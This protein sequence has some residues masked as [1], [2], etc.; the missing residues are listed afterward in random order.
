M[1][2]KDVTNREDAFHSGLLSLLRMVLTVF[3]IPMELCHQHK[4]S[5][6][7]G[8]HL[9]LITVYIYI[10]SNFSHKTLTNCMYISY[11]QIRRWML[12]TDLTGRGYCLYNEIFGF[13]SFNALISQTLISA[14]CFPLT[15]V[16]SGDSKQCLI[17]Q[18]AAD[19]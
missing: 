3:S 19:T 13:S 9:H 4:I 18:V 7:F 6:A 15:L 5:E 12:S 2:S 14:Y 11:L 16:T 8:M 17:M 1:T 10:F